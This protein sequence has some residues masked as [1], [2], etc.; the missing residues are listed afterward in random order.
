MTVLLI[1]LI[2]LVS[3]SLVIVSTLL[4]ACRNNDHING[5]WVPITI[6]TNKSF[7]CCGGI[8]RFSKGEN[9]FLQMKD[10]CGQ[11]NTVVTYLE[12]GL[13][14][15]SAQCGDD[16]CKCDRENNTRLVPGNREKYT[17]VPHNCLLFGWNATWF[18]ELLGNR[19]LLLVGDSAMQQTSSTLMSMVSR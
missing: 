12:V 8:N 13:T 10:Y 2:I 11:I 3:W 17:W 4:E 19:V 15:G 18:C 6:P 14:T 7:I 9:D 1:L 16:C 5:S